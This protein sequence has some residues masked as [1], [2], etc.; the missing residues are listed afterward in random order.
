MFQFIGYSFF[1]GPDALDSAPSQ[2]DKITTTR[3]TNAIF[4]HFNITKDVNIEYSDKKPDGWTYDTVLDADFNGDI[5]GGNVNFMIEQI[6]AVKI[7]RRKR[8]TF[9]WMTLETIPITK[10]EDLSFLFIDRLNAHGIDYEYAFVPILEDIEGDYII[11]SILSQFNGVFIGDFNSTYRLLYEANYGTIMKNQQVATFNPLGRKYPV[12]VAN[13]MSSY[14]SGTVMA[15]ILDDGF[16]ETGKIDSVETNNKLIEINNF[17]ANKKPKVLRDMN[18][19][20]WLCMITGNSQ[21]SYAAGTWMT[22][23]RVQFSWTEIGDA[24]SQKDLYYNGVLKT[25]N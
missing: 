1:S 10:V 5:D 8:G 6:S 4:D 2:V 21:T 14:D 25:L 11:N 7:K 16:Q 12:I 13:G 17:L 22:V 24:E 20:E 23:P 19:K 15:T 9:T 18:G 3:L